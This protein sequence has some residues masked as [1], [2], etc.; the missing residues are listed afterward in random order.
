[1]D[2][3]IRELLEAPFPDEEIRTREGT[4]GKELAYAEVHNYIAR[5]NEAFAALSANKE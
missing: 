1:M 5:L 4:F 2:K 3:N